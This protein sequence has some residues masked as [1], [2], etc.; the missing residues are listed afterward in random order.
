MC[1]TPAET[2]GSSR[3]LRSGCSRCNG[4]SQALLRVRKE[5]VHVLSRCCHDQPAA[6]AHGERPPAVPPR[7]IGGNLLRTRHSSLS[8]GCGFDP[9]GPRHA[10]RLTFSDA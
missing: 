1:T 9:T 6:T 2:G 8:A 7:G 3:S 5:T 10:R 4:S